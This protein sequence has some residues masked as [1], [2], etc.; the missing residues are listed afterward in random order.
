[1]SI[2]DNLILRLCGIIDIEYKICQNFDRKK[3]KKTI[4]EH[5]PPIWCA[6]PRLD[7]SEFWPYLRP[8][9]RFFWPI[10]QTELQ[11]QFVNLKKMILRFSGIIYIE[12]EIC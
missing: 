11:T 1:M 8:E 7:I 10:I 3:V 5:L 12:Y 4:L 6:R 2:L 9:F